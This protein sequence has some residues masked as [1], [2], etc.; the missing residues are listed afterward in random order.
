M[1]AR[2]VRL[3]DLLVLALAAALVALTLA[4]VRLAADLLSNKGR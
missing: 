4:A 1:F 3:S 2:E